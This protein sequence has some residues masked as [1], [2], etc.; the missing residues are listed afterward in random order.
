MPFP[1]HYNS[2]F[3][4]SIKRQKNQP[5]SRLIQLVKKVAFQ[6]HQQAAKQN[7]R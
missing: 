1:P 5:E 4:Y 2:I 6:R 7:P 3:E